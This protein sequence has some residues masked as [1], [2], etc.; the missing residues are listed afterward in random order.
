MQLNKVCYISKVHKSSL[1]PSSQYVST[2]PLMR[3][4]IK[5]EAISTSTDAKTT[6]FL[7]FSVLPEA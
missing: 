5:T 7:A 3:L 6:V 2:T 1:L 4:G